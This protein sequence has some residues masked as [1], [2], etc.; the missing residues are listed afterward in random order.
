MRMTTGT[1]FEALGELLRRKRKAAIVANILSGL[2]PLH[3]ILIAIGAR[4]HM[5]YVV[6][7]LL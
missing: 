4:K 6:D 1:I 2:N 3:Q 5:A 7:R